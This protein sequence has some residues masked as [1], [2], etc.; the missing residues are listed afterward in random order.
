MSKVVHFEFPADAPDKLCT[1]FSK[2]FGWEFQQFG[3]EDYYLTTA[4]ADEEQGIGGAIM[5]RNDKDQP[6]VT[7][8][9]V[10]SIE[11]TAKVIEQHGGKLVVEKAPVADMGFYAYFKDPEGQIHGLWESV[12]K[13]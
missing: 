1:F 6:I 2:V 13:D 7:V 8:I 9:N 5:K 11:E 3:E 4:G 12:K 10:D